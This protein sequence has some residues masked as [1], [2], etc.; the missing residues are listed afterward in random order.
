MAGT[1]ML[2][3]FET[4]LVLSGGN[5]LGAYHL[6]VCEALLPA[7]EPGWIVGCSI[8]AVTGAILLGNPA[9]GR[10]ARLREFWSEVGIHDRPWAR[11]M[12][13]PLRARWSNGLGL[14]ALLAGRRGVTAPRFP[15]L[16]SLLPGMP[17]DVSL[18]DH[19]PLAALL[20]RLVDWDRLNASPIRFSFL[21][22]DLERG[23]E[24]WWDNRRDR[25]TARHVLASTAL[26][27][28]LPPVELD[29]R[30]HWDGGLGNNL[31]VDHV[32]REPSPR[33]LLVIAS[34]LYAPE[35]ERPGSLD[36]AA[37]RAQD[38]GFALQARTRI[39][40]MARER[41]LLR[42][43]EP[44]TPP[45]ILVHL[46]HR[47]SAHQRALKALDFSGTAVEERVAQGRSD[48]ETALRLLP[49]TP[50]DEPLA[51]VTVPPA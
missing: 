22:I 11:L 44:E 40:A 15:G 6:G 28:L 41:E 39:G 2:E 14:N 46:V 45:A 50:R 35:G 17:P 19:R 12:P 24:V 49:A 29:G 18:Q 23:E 32:L 36:G 51:V 9:E 4:V 16:L 38:L 5:A 34:D 25:V 27:P 26:P 20:D 30:W 47:P 43:A 3:G 1:E 48:M 37:L 31:P 13:M 10:L 42:R 21:A 33:P 8:G 7:A